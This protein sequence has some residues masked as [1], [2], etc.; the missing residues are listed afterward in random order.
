MSDRH[1]G[2]GEAASTP[3]VDQDTQ[4][5]TSVDVANIPWVFT[6]SHPLN[7]EGFIGEAK[8]RGFDLD[9]SEVRELYRNMLVVPFVYIGPQR[10][11]PVPTPIVDEPSPHGT[12]QV[13]FESAAG[14]DV[15]KT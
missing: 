3:A 7:T 14:V 8:K 13:E 1:A 11:G 2:E 15:C 12:W 9:L 4:V 10:V 5:L 6:Q